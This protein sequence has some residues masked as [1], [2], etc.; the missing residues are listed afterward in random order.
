MKPEMP[1]IDS[2]IPQNA[3]SV[4]AQDG[5]EEFPVLKAFQQYIDA[6]Q[7]KARKRML[8]MA[9][10]FSLIM[11]AVIAVF[12]ALILHS[13]E[14]NQRQL[15]KLTERNQQLNDRL[16]EFAT[17]ER[18]Q[19][20]TSTAA[21]VVVQPPQDSSALLALTA[22]LDEMQKKLAESQAKAERDAKEAADRAEKA[23]IEAAKPKGP[24]K[25]ELEIQKLKELLKA[26]DQA[27]AEFAREEKARIQAEKEAKRQAEIEEYRRKHYPELYK[28]VKTQPK[29]KEKRVVVEDV[30]DEIDEEESSSKIDALLKELDDNKAIRYY[31]DEDEEVPT[32]SLSLKKSPSRKAEKKYSIPVDQGSSDSTWNIPEE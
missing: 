8:T 17:R 6:E 18:L 1:D 12:V 4:Y 9:V 16:V 21:P 3:V 15:D 27:A 32:K 11:I 30:D 23:A 5:Q 24:T 14:R 19:P 29:T 31:D 22:K 26:R 10:F 2:E 7:E 25:E 28:P 13:T 20:A